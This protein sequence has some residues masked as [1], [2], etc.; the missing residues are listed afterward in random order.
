MKI[1]GFFK[2]GK[3]KMK[4][5]ITVPSNNFQSYNAVLNSNDEL[6]ITGTDGNG[7]AFQQTLPVQPGSVIMFDVSNHSFY[8]YRI[9][10]EVNANMQT[11]TFVR[12]I[13]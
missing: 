11:V 12:D 9:D 6:E 1:L 5:L 10:G 3:Y 8:A 7:V 4:T 2:K 13:A